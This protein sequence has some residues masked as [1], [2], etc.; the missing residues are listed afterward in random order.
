MV[1]S[2][3]YILN[4]SV[5]LSK[6]NHVS[7]IKACIQFIRKFYGALFYDYI[8]IYILFLGTASAGHLKLLRPRLPISLPLLVCLNS[9]VRPLT[10]I[11]TTSL[12]RSALSVIESKYVILNRNLK[13]PNPSRH[14][15]TLSSL[16]NS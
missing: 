11:L 14:D 2:D 13:R 1:S 6:F 9:L 4:I 5:Y 10:K 7:K 16:S 12:L 8:F 3:L 15:T